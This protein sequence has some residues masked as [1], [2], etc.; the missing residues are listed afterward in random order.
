MN[1]EQERLLRLYPQQ[2]GFFLMPATLRH[3]LNACLS[4]N[5]GKVFGPIQPMIYIDRKDQTV[6]RCHRTIVD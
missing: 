2:W 4:T 1:M 6:M 3:K 5:Q